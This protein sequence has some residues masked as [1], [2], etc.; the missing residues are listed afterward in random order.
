MDDFRRGWRE[1]QSGIILIR[2]RNVDER[3]I[4]SCGDVHGVP[5]KGLDYTGPR[6]ADVII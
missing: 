5:L 2:G 3:A 4:R 1:Y 6:A